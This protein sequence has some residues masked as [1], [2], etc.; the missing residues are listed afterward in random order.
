MKRILQVSLTFLFIGLLVLPASGQKRRHVKV[1]G[2][3]TPQSNLS[4]EPKLRPPA[5]RVFNHKESIETSYDRFKDVTVVR[6]EMELRKHSDDYIGPAPL[7]LTIA[8]AYQGQRL[9]TAP[10]QI[11]FSLQKSFD[12]D[13]L[14]Y[15]PR[16]EL[17][18]QAIF[19]TDDKRISVVANTNREYHTFWG[20][21][22]VDSFN[23]SLPYD[24]FLLLVNSKKV[25]AQ[26]ANI[27]LA[28]N[29]EQLEA[30]R[31]LAS[32]TNPNAKVKE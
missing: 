3:A 16:P 2:K 9:V 14:E 1:T 30:L 23:F 12:K 18:S 4:E 28:L 15:N 29:E 19:L 7:A 10:S 32:R 22:Y 26:I 24:A 6:L 21:Y 13:L 5:V 27:E 17:R 11:Y 20:R 25:E 31:D 8:F